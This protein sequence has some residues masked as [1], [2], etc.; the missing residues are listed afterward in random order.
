MKLFFQ[1]HHVF[2]YRKLN[3][4]QLSAPPFLD[5]GRSHVVLGLPRN[6]QNWQV[7]QNPLRR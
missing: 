1:K 7:Y 4:C 2:H 3:G 5:T 6:S